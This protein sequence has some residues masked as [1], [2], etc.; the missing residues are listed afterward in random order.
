MKFLKIKLDNSPSHSILNE[1]LQSYSQVLLDI[2]YTHTHKQL[3]GNYIT[4]SVL[5]KSQSEYKFQ[6]RYG[7]NGEN[8]IIR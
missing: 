4:I 3:S 7:A 6:N 8:E 2:I 1:K 5:S